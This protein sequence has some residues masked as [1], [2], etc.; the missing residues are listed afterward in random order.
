MQILRAS[1]KW[2]PQ[3]K[4]LLQT[5]SRSIDATHGARVEELAAVRGITPDLAATIQAEPGQAVLGS[6]M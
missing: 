4:A 3:Y 5:F 1:C 6:T 2:V